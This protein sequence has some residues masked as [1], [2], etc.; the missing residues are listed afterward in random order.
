MVEEG[1]GGED[2]PAYGDDVELGDVVVLKDA[3]SHLQPV[4]RRDL[5][6]AQDETRY[7]DL[8][9]QYLDVVVGRIAVEP[10]ELQALA[11]NVKKLL[12]LNWNL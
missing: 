2:G 9:P 8:R 4:G 11:K 3:L 5:Q 7:E 6:V 1:H 10:V 12:F